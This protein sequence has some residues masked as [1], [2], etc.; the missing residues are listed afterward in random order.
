MRWP[1]HIR[2][3]WYRRQRGRKDALSPLLRAVEK[4]PPPEGLLLKIEQALGETKTA[5]TKSRRSIALQFVVASPVLLGVW[6]LLAAPLH[7]VSLIDQS[8]RPI[9]QLR[10]L[11]GI[12]KAKMIIAPVSGEANMGWHFWGLPDDDAPVHL[13]ALESGDL[14][15]DGPDQFTLF[16]VSLE[17][18]PFFGDQPLGPVVELLAQEK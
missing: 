13:G 9:V 18:T 3:R 16:A 7:R 11:N 17:R 2:P 1:R 6:L 8:G 5:P 14:V 10:T 15:I 12:T 4:E